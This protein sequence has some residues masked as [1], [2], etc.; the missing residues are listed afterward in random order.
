MSAAPA[1]PIHPEQ[2]GEAFTKSTRTRRVHIHKVNCVTCGS[3]IPACAANP[4]G[5]CLA[6]ENQLDLF[7]L[8][9]EMVS[10]SEAEVKA[11]KGR[12][13]GRVTA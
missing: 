6:C 8:P 12:K 4:K 13:K 11:R 10:A 1:E 2:D 5:E 3:R 9:A 7:A